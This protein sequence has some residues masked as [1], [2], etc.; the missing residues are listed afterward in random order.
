[1][2]GGL[3]LA[4]MLMQGQTNGKLCLD[5]DA[6]CNLIPMARACHSGEGFTVMEL[7]AKC[8]R[9]QKVK[10][11]SAA[12]KRIREVLVACNKHKP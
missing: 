8:A 5:V 9:F 4:L 11:K 1:M 7:Q 2:I 6:Q 10:R 12:A 3:I